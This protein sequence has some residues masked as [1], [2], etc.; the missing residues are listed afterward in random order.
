MKGAKPQ[1]TITLTE[2]GQISVNGPLHDKILC[3]GMLEMAKEAVHNFKP[4]EVDLIKPPF[5]PFPPKTG[6]GS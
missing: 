5:M 2:L 6:A 1:I 4:G 3:F